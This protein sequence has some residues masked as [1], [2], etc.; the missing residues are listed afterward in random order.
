M[1]KHLSVDQLSNVV[2][3]ADQPTQPPGVTRRDVAEAAW[4]ATNRTLNPRSFL[5]AGP[6]AYRQFNDP[7]IKDAGFGIRALNGALGLFGIDP[8]K[9][10]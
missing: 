4:A 10:Q 8:L 7:R 3:G 6:Q 1:F 5:G 9:K 2:G